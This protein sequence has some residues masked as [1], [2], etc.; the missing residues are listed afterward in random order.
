MFTSLDILDVAVQLERNGE[1]IF[2]DAARAVENAEL[3]ELLEWMADQE[4]EHVEYFENMKTTVTKPFDDPAIQEMGREIL[5]D[6]LEG[7]GFDLGN[8]DFSKM[9][10][11]RELLNVS[12][13][14]E[15]DTATF[16][17]LLKSFVDD[18]ET[19]ELLDKIIE[20]EHNHARLL[21]EFVKSPQMA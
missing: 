11:I 4:K 5:Q 16:Y 6:A 14:F 18:D 20:E 7:V 2:R 10:E 19:R 3:S 12:I 15:K 17:E 9:E 8:V 21:R 13:A 1:K